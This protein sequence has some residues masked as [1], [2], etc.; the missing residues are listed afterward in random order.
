MLYNSVAKNKRKTVFFMIGFVIMISLVVYAISYYMNKNEAIFLTVIAFIFTIASCFFSYY[1]S[2]KLVLRMAHA[3]PVD[4]MQEPYLYNTIEGVAMA[5]NVPVPKM[6]IIET[7]ML[8]AFATGRNPE[9]SAI[10]VTRGLLNALNREELEG[11]IAHEMSHIKNYD[12]LLSTIIVVLAGTLV[13]LSRLF[14]RASFFGGGKG[15]SRNSK[16]NS[17]GAGA[18]I[19]IVGLILLILAPIFATLVQLA[20][21]RNREYL[22]DASAAQILG[23]PLGLASALKKLQQESD[24]KRAEKEDFANSA[25][26]GLF[27][28]NP[29]EKNLNASSLFSTHPPLEERIKRL[30]A[31]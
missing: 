15:R 28:I 7:D 30:E 22:A 8:N 25:N 18:I 27:I 5:A 14:V 10:C 9:H 1:N 21:S 24:P 13:F 17:G 29:L 3:I 26:A 31:M 4:R 20:L 6:Y 23:Y 16:D 19:A 12:V 2:D 11:V